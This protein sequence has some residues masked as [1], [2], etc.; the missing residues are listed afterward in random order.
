MREKEYIKLAT[1]KTE[2]VGEDI[3]SVVPKIER[4]KISVSLQEMKCKEVIHLVGEGSEEAKKCVIQTR[5]PLL[6]IE[7]KEE[8]DKQIGKKHFMKQ[9]LV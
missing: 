9:P 4:E 7:C 1:L 5:L 8:N 3:A 2:M 6:K